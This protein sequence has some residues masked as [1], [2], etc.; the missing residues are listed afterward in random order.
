M[1][2]IIFRGTLD[3]CLRHMAS[4]PFDTDARDSLAKFAGVTVHPS[5]YRWLA[6][7]SDPVG[8]QL[9]R[10]RYYLEHIGYDVEELRGIDSAVAD[11]GRMIAFRV[12][13]VD[14]LV[15]EL[16][17]GGTM[18]SAR[19][20][21]YRLLLGKSGQESEKM[22]KVRELAA[23]FRDILDEKRSGT[24]KIRPITGSGESSVDLERPKPVIEFQAKAVRSQPT[25][26]NSER[27]V[28]SL[29]HSVLAMIPLAEAMLSDGVSAE[30]RKRLRD[31]AGGDGVFRLSNLLNRLCSERARNE[32]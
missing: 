29:A 28:V 20:Q 23:S 17:Y 8:E 26:S 1:S 7:R 13:E 31:L 2:K 10:V 3:E 5:A 32:L 24:P 27:M 11:I 16:G 22:S 12:L 25:P 18:S 21:T 14:D 15:T 30:D 19:S 9:L 6:R 4:T